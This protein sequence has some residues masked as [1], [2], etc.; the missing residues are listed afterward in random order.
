MYLFLLLDRVRSLSLTI[1]SVWRGKLGLVAGFL[2]PYPAGTKSG[3][4]VEQSVQSDQALHCWLTSFEQILFLISPE[5]IRD[6]SKKWK[7]DKSILRAHFIIIRQNIT[8][9]LYFYYL[10]PSYTGSSCILCIKIHQGIYCN[11]FMT[12]NKSVSFRTLPYPSLMT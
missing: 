9:L 7:V 12:Y 1:D 3:T 5:L 10:R 6:S 2:H 11:F 8:I 4:S